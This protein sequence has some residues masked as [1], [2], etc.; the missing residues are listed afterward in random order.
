MSFDERGFTLVEMLM[1]IVVAGLVAAAMFQLLS[2]QNRFYGEVSDRS[3]AEETL[4]A[5]VELAASELRM[6]ASGD[7][8]AARSDSVAVRADVLRAYVCHVTTLDNVYF[9][10]TEG[11]SGGGLL[12]VTPGLLDSRGTAYAAPFSKTYSYDDGFDATGTQSSTAQTECEA[13]GVPSGM[14]AARYRVKGWG[15]SLASP[16]PG[17]T[18][19]VYRK[20]SYHFAPSEMGDGLALWRNEGELGSPFDTQGAGFR[21]RV[22]AGGSCTW[23][24]TVNDASD[25]RDIR[26]IELRGRALGDGANRYD[27][28]LDLDYDFTLRNYIEN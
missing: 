8:L 12:S 18:L 15:G 1:A 22:C 23:H 7:V 4:R 19:R 26:R 11:V 13:R 9:Y 17:A 6:A 27:V 2:D 24:T 16:E 20:L 25:Q 10:V 21:Y 3:Y 14:D 28:G 5:S